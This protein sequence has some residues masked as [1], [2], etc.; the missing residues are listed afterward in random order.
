MGA[1]RCNEIIERVLDPLED[2][3]ADAEREV[4]RLL[5]DR[6][7]QEAAHYLAHT[8]ISMLPIT[9]IHDDFRH[10]RNITTHTDANTSANATAQHYELDKDEDEDEDED[11]G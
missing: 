1:R 10:N 11:E 2:S 7:P 4:T 3:L 8:G 6:H 5:L 9:Q